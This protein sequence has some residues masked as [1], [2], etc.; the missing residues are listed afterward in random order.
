MQY[1]GRHKRINRVHEGVKFCTDTKVVTLI[2]L[3]WA[4]NYDEE[5]N[6]Y[7]TEG[8]AA[9]NAYRITGGS[10]SYLLIVEFPTRIQVIKIQNRVE[11]KHVAAF[12]LA[13]PYRV[14]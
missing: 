13:T 8:L 2:T 9:G 3:S 11:D 14:C 5:L 1:R 12:S 7:R 6:Y 10:D 4:G